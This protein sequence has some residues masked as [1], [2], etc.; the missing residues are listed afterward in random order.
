MVDRIY[1]YEHLA[2]ATTWMADR[3]GIAAPVPEPTN[4]S[5]ARDVDID[6]GIRAMLEA[7]FAGDVA[8]YEGARL[9]SGRDRA[10]ADRACRD[11]RDDPEP[12]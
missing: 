2:A 10:T 1:R 3:L 9:R 5:P 6:A 8:M 7:H 4:V 12:G 11:P